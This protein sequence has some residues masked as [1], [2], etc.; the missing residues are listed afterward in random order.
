MERIEKISFDPRTEKLQNE[1]S[2]CSPDVISITVSSG[3]H[4]ALQVPMK[5][6]GSLLIFALVSGL[7]AGSIFAVTDSSTPITKKARKKRKAVGKTAVAAK[8]AT[9]TAPTAAASV[10]VASA[11]TK[12]KVWVQTWDEPTYKDS[13]AGDRTE[14]EDATI[15]KA[16]VEALGPYNGSVVVVDPEQAAS[17]R[18]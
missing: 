12:R 16:A 10:A 13:A 9:V 5:R 4:F 15:R 14:G 2:G 7:S 11:R 8:P 3:S 18:W 1:L 6:L 17:F